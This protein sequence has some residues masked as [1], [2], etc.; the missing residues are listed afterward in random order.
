M[1]IFNRFIIYPLQFIIFLKIYFF[2]K[3]LSNKTASNLGGKIFRILGPLSKTNLIL[4][5]FTD[6]Y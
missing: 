5:K 4:L 6:K 2:F 3:L 1:K